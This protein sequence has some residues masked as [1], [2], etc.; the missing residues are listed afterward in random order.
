M[1]RVV[2]GVAEAGAEFPAAAA[3]PHRSGSRMWIR[4]RT[5]QVAGQDA[6]SNRS[7]PSPNASVNPPADRS[8]G[9]VGTALDSR[10]RGQARAWC[11][12]TQVEEAVGERYPREA[13]GR[14]SK[15]SSPRSSGIR[16]TPCSPTVG[17]TPTAHAC[18]VEHRFR[19]HVGP[20]AR[21]FRR[22]LALPRDSGADVG[23]KFAPRS[24]RSSARPKQSNPGPRLA[25]VA[26]ARAVSFAAS[27]VELR[28]DGGGIR[29][30]ARGS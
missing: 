9:V 26:G 19:H 22:A 13:R 23:V 30:H 12:Q 14:R 16:L 17:K 24:R 27:Q 1:S 4:A 18:R 6:G 7:A 5:P 3:R 28:G 2:D 29:S 25:D 15:D 11:S 21:G 8:G 20:V 10:S